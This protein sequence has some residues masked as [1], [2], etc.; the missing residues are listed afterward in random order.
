VLAITDVSITTGISAISRER[1]FQNLNTMVQAI[2]QFG[3][4]A[5]ATYLN[6]GEYFS[7][8]AA[9]LGMDADKIV[10]SDEQVQAEQQAQRQAQIEAEQAMRAQEH[11]QNV[12]LEAQKQEANNA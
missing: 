11:G 9:S 3:P 6:M 4:D 5:M 10:K 7:Q 1:D 12:D 8:V 2:T